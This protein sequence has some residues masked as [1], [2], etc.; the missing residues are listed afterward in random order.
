MSSQ[1]SKPTSIIRS[2]AGIITVDYLFAFSLVMGFSALLFAL[3]FTLS[4]A[5]ITQYITFATARTYYG[6][7]IDMTTQKDLAKVKYS[8]LVNHPVF[9]PLYSNGWFQVDS[10]TEPDDF[11]SFYDGGPKDVF[12]GVRVN[13][14]ASMLD[15]H[16]PFYGST[17]STET[18]GGG[19]STVIGSY[20]G[21]EPTV[22]E[23][24]QL[25][26]ADRWAQ[27]RAL[28]SSYSQNTTENG[29]QVITD[30]GC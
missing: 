10:E 29:Y 27:L 6:S 17:S 12:H 13:F 2:E 30:N 14:I 21:R 22:N 11:S 7:H 16:I 26:A 3:T 8:Q 1:R 24:I 20:L 25:F 15:F 5:E 23:C 9:K 4:V 19:F 18:E 28:D